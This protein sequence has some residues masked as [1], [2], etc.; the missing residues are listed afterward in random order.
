[1]WLHARGPIQNNENITNAFKLRLITKVYAFAYVFHLVFFNGKSVI[2]GFQNLNIVARVR[3][4]T[5]VVLFRRRR[6]WSERTVLE[7]AQETFCCVCRI[8]IIYFEEASK[9]RP[10]P[11]FLAYTPYTP[12]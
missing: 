12:A 8:L 3:S 1:M 7:C 11:S 2:Y 4:S 10:L 5:T 6:W 9:P